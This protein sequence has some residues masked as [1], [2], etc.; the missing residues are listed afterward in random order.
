MFKPAP[1]VYLRA[2]ESVGRNPCHC[3]AVED[4]ASGVGSASNAG[5]GLI[6]GY[7]GGG[8]IQ[9]EAETAHARML[10]AGEKAQNKRGADIVITHMQDLP[11]V[12]EQFAKLQASRPCRDAPLQLTNMTIS[13]PAGSIIT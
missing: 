6:V 4:S 12:V 9:S 10:M 1:H 5:I 2:A 8:H 3:I 11:Q 13:D 7:V